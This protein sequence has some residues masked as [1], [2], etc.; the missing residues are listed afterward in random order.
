[1]APS[2]V[3]DAGPS[4]LEVY[5]MGRTS[6]DDE[7]SIASLRSNHFKASGRCRDHLGE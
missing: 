3:P 2:I 4:S 7:E 5:W 6:S 1:M